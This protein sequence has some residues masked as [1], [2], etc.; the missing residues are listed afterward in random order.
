MSMSKVIDATATMTLGDNQDSCIGVGAGASATDTIM[1]DEDERYARAETLIAIAKAYVDANPGHLCIAGSA[2]LWLHQGKPRTWFP[3]DVDVFSYSGHAFGKRCG[4]RVDVEVQ[5]PDPDKQWLVGGRLVMYQHDETTGDTLLREKDGTSHTPAFRY[6]LDIK[7]IGNKYFPS[8]RIMYHT[9]EYEGLGKIQFILTGMFATINDVFDSF[10]L[11]C[12][13]V[14]YTTKRFATPVDSAVGPVVGPVCYDKERLDMIRRGD[15][16]VP[17]KEDLCYGADF[18]TEAACAWDVGDAVLEW[19]KRNGLYDL[20][21]E[22]NEQLPK[23]DEFDLLL[24]DKRLVYT[25]EHH[26]EDAL[27]GDPIKEDGFTRTEKRVAKY[28]ERGIKFQGVYNLAEAWHHNYDTIAKN[29]I[30]WFR[31]IYFRQFDGKS[32][33]LH[34]DVDFIENRERVMRIKACS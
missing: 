31:W 20:V 4:S 17:R 34:R 24:C 32:Y 8:D 12:C 22:A 26:P 28:M 2:A 5:R 7:G 3:N 29:P 25:S 33:H 1:K 21:L 6:S 16:Y 27:V 14:G 13:R 18:S 30:F 10:D 9:Y 15:V 19:K 23:T 11:T